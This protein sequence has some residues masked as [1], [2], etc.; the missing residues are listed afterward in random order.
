MVKKIILILMATLNVTFIY[1]RENKEA[2][3]LTFDELYFQV[4]YNEIDDSKLQD[5]WS[6][7][8]RLANDESVI[9]DINPTLKGYKE[10][11]KDRCYG[12]SE[13]EL[14]KLFNY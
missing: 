9:E 8:Y 10:F 1:A 11:L 14:L 7:C 2:K 6:I 12:D 3:K 4:M 13:K 5:Y